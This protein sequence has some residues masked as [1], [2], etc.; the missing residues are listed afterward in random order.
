V[1][2]HVEKKEKDAN[3]YF[4]VWW[5]PLFRLVK[6]TIIRRIP[7]EAG[8]FEIYRDDGDREPVLVG[9]ARAYY[10]GLRNT[11]RGMIDESMPYPL[12]G[13]LLDLSRKHFVRYA[14]L[15]SYDDM[16]D[17]LFFFANRGVIDN[18][19]DDSGRYAMI[20]V[21]EGSLRPDGRPLNEAGK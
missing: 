17:V 20:Y 14:L 9:R 18:E 6:D 21:K 3:A 12:N 4:T 15:R 5:S 11:L 10:G 8:I 13:R 16:D 2:P 1:T 7:S 19:A